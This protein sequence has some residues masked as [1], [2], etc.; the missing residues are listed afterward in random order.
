MIMQGGQHMVSFR[1]VAVFIALVGLMF[2]LAG[3]ADAAHTRAHRAQTKP[4]GDGVEMTG[5]RGKPEMILQGPVASVNPATGFI[6][7][8]HGAGKDAEEI[9]VEIDSK[10]SL[11]RAGRRANIDEIRAGDRVKISYSGQPGDVSKTVDVMTG[12]GMR[13][14]AGKA[15]A[16]RT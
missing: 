16:K 3:V 15:R 4:T 10:T 8:R 6:V 9:P 11:M 2:G 5:R 1:K 12:A 7:I 13:P 14:G